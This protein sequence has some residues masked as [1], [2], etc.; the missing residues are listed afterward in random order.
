[1]SRCLYFFWALCCFPFVQSQAQDLDSL[2]N[3]NAYTTES[4]LQKVLNKNVAVSTL[5]LSSRESP[6]IVTV[7]NR[8]E[9]RN[10]GARDLT[11]VLRLVPGFD[12]MQDLQFVLGLSLRGN[13]ANEGKVLVL[14]DGVPFNELLYQSVAV[15]NRFP[16]DAVERI[17]IIRGPG[18]A[19]YG[20]SAEY[21]VINI[22]TRAAE[23]LDG[24]SA[25]G[26]TGLHSNAVGRINA[27]IMAGQKKE[28]WA[29]DISAFKGK[30][31]V[32]DQRFGET[33][34]ADSTTSDPI[35][36]SAGFKTRGFSLRTMYDE[37]KTS[38]PYSAI[39]F[40]TYFVDAKYEIQVSDKFKLTPEVQ[41]LNQ[42]PWEYDYYYNN[43]G[44]SDPDFRYRAKRQ[45][46]Q[47]DA[48]YTF[49]RRVSVNFG[50]LYF[51]D[52]SRDIVANEDILTLNNFAFYS[53]ALFKHRLANATLGFRFEK[54]NRYSGAFVPR[55]A[56]TKK[57]E[58]FHFKLLY[59]KSFRSPSLQ[60]VVLDT[61]GS[62]PEKSDVFEFEL[63]YQFTPEMLLAV[64]AFYITTRDVIIYG[65]EGDGD[66]F[67]EWYENYEKSGSKGVELVYSI[68][69][70]NWYTNLTYSFNQS[71]EGNTVGKYQMPQTSKQ[72]TGVPA[73]KFTFNINYNIRPDVNVNAS[74]I[75]VGKRYAYTDF[76]EEGPVPGELDPYTLLNLFA[77]YEPEFLK[78]LGVGAGVFDLLN[79][80]PAIPQAYNG[81]AGAYL[82]VPGR[83]REV[84]F[85]LRYQ[86]D[87]RK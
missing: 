51:Q 55:F 72:Y 69:K 61:T 48:A 4:E 74:F 70:K 28:N 41:Y 85:K 34:L 62:K 12:V 13:W 25:Y 17:E 57:I 68:R 86:L 77:N 29:W 15:G 84:V 52:N 44:S 47:L 79:E 16:V 81:E 27:G 76:D 23:S 39:S 56:I 67:K 10:S 75:A 63:G 19:N 21:G 8:E 58:N 65:S 80:R 49:S 40:Q 42:V 36:I 54:N 78:G 26:T 50:G 1:M 33:D 11:D 37:F 24:V 66:D 2:F 46:A 9:I 83:S 6:A 73:Q 64:N 35:N 20:G 43:D 14:M 30:G 22:I 71:I 59:S 53:Q 3:L 18:S 7:I 31:N 45:L 38:D 87:F 5:K 82:P 32:S 60:N